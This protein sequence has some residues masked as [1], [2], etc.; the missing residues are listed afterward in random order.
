MAWTFFSNHGLVLLAVARRPSARIRDL[1]GKVGI[2]ERAA[3]SIVNDLVREGYL[4]RVREGRR[5]RY[6]VR[7]DRPLRHATTRD[8]IVAELVQAVGGG[9]ALE[10][11]GPCE[12]LVL[13]CSDHRAQPALHAFLAGQGLLGRAEL[14]L[15]PGGGPALTGPDR[16]ILFAALEMLVAEHRPDRVLLLA[17]SD[18]RVPNVPRVAAAG[19][20]DVYRSVVRWA[21]RIVDEAHERVGAV[22][23]LWFLTGGAASQVRVQ[24]ARQVGGRHAAAGKP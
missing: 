2:T 24:A 22:P 23:E 10:R 5:N 16:D 17:H 13:A 7:G 20:L 19:V 18:C 8:H 14:L 12:A 3:Q 6:V 4:E 15:W 9:A 1:A 21:E 11:E